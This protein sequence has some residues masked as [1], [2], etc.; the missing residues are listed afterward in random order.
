MSTLKWQSLLAAVIIMT[1][2]H[3]KSDDIMFLA[4]I[5]TYGGGRGGCEGQQCQS[6]TQ[7]SVVQF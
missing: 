2:V 5:F 7:E 4:A 1:V 3:H 6:L